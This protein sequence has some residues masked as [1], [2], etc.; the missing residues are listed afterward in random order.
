MVIEDTANSTIQGSG[1]KGKQEGTDL[2][3]LKKVIKK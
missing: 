1:S 2:A 3:H